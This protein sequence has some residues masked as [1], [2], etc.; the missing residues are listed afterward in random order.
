MGNYVQIGGV[1]NWP[2]GVTE[3]EQNA[4]I[5]RA[6]SLI[7][8][9][10]YRKHYQHGFEVKVP[11]SG[12]GILDLGFQEKLA[13]VTSAVDNRTGA[14]IVGWDFD[15]YALFGVYF[16]AGHNRI[17]VS[18]VKGPENVPEDIRAAALMYVRFLNDETLYE[19]YDRGNVRHGSIDMTFSNRPRTNVLEIDRILRHYKRRLVVRVV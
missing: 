3:A 8:T 10:T 7:E 6:E 9:V 17:T 12:A 4:M 5:N 15:D 14:E 1:D 18:G 19:S 16:P 11:G 13:D 2:S